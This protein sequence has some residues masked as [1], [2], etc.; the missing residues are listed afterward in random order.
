[1][2]EKGIEIGKRQIEDL[3]LIDNSPQSPVNGNG[4][5]ESAAD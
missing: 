1:M 3:A 5:V 2:Q 4:A